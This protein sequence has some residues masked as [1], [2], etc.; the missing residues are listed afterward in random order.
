M[1]T[2]AVREH[3]QL[4]DEE[5]RLSAL[6]DENTKAEPAVVE[7]ERTPQ[8]GERRILARGMNFH[9]AAAALVEGEYTLKDEEGPILAVRVNLNE[10]GT[11]LA[12]RRRQVEGVW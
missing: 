11:T 10:S 6:R 1:T 2:A 7:R 8:A 3:K 4:L 5:T 9:E 12:G